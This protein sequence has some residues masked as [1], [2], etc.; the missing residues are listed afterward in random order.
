MLLSAVVLGIISWWY[1]VYGAVCEALLWHLSTSFTDSRDRRQSEPHTRERQ[2][3]F[4][5]AGLLVMWPMDSR[6][7]ADER[8]PSLTAD[9][10]PRC[11]ATAETLNGLHT[12]NIY[13]D[14]TPEAWLLTAQ[15]D[16]PQSYFLYF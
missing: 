10:A 11:R 9:G 2:S 16:P 8:A 6:P 5:P 3:S 4:C 13:T 12:L 15:H 1:G 7:L 14:S